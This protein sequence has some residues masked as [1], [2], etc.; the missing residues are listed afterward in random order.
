[1]KVKD[2]RDW[3]GQRVFLVLSNGFSFTGVIPDF[4]GETFSFIDK[5]GNRVD[6]S[7][8]IIELIYSSNK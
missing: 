5:F 3:I 2:V 6:I 7:C 4:D 8:K 1:M